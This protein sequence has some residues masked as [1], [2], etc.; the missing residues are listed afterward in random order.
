MRDYKHVVAVACISG[1]LAVVA[2]GEDFIVDQGHDDVFAGESIH[3]LLAFPSLTQ[4]FTP[5]LSAIDVVEIFTRDWSNPATNGVGAVLQVTLREDSTNGPV[6]AV[7]APT[8]FPD[9]WF[10]PSRFTFTNLVWITPGKRYAFELKL[11]AGNNWGVD[12][13]GT[14]APPY[15]EG[16]YFIGTNLMQ[17]SDLWFRTGVRPPPARLSSVVPGVLR[18]KAVAPLSYSV[19]TSDTLTNWFHAGFVS[20]ESTEYAFTNGATANAMFYRVS[21]P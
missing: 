17:N 4:E 10:G 15:R 13:Y 2:R 19:W 21:V 8:E 9:G 18:W 6:L 5:T 20:S 14:F 16:R 3:S 11:L 1:A 12:S 7:S